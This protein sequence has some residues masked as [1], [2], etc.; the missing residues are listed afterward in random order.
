M[1][2]P[3]TVLLFYFPF[4]S[5]THSLWPIL[6]VS[7]HI[8]SGIMF[9]VKAKAILPVEQLVIHSVA[10]RGQLGGLTVWVS[11]DTIAPDRQG[12]YAF[13]L[14]PRH[15]TKVYDQKHKPC[16]R[17]H[18]R[19]YTTL[20]LSASPVILRPGQV[21]VLYIHS[22]LPGDEAIVYDNT[23]NEVPWGA[24]GPAR[25]QDNFIS[26]HTGKAHLSPV[27]FNQSPIWGWGN[28]WYVISGD[29]VVHG[30]CCW[31]GKH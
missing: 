16:G 29:I 9:P 7:L 13:R 21:R 3:H 27:P 5:V 24:P 23:P 20:D 18:Q 6:G 12:Q 4:D 19:Q 22:T 30:C 2:V 25:V 17:S 1:G 26:I 31:V 8:F 14:S 11:N 15:W 10:V 28:A